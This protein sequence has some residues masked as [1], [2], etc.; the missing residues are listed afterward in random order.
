MSAE[1]IMD[2][3]ADLD[4][5]LIR[6]AV[7]FREGKQSAL[8][9]VRRRRMVITAAAL[10]AS[11]LLVY[12]IFSAGFFRPMG[13][14]E[15]GSAS[16]AP[17][18]AEGQEAAAEMSTE[19][20]A[21]VSEEAVPEETVS[22]E[23]H[24]Q[25]LSKEAAEDDAA[26]TAQ[27]Q[28]GALSVSNDSD[29]AVLA[30][31]ADAEEDSG[32]S[33]FAMEEAEESAE[34]EAAEDYLMASAGS[35]EDTQTGSILTQILEYRTSYD[36]KESDAGES[37][38]S[39][40]SRAAKAAVSAAQVDGTQYTEIPLTEEGMALLREA[41]DQLIETDETMDW[42]TVSGE[43]DRQYLISHNENTEPEFRLWV[44]ENNE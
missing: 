24:V 23:A 7:R 41:A 4:E 36:L 44:K 39:A 9:I 12:F 38:A 26:L 19:V 11:G 27:S 16:S 34:E 20:T 28:N 18:V 17:A 33:V 5:D 15:P 35:L 8:R 3:I 21:A 10:A 37:E 22:E 6:E 2:A 29:A 31:S 43:N 30:E 13:S 14:S 1:M 40:Q 25:M 42:Y 32:L